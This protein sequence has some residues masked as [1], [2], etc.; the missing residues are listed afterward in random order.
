MNNNIHNKK[1]S[2]VTI[3]SRS[4]IQPYM[5]LQLPL[6]DL[7]QSCLILCFGLL[8]FTESIADPE[9]PLCLEEGGF[10]HC[11]DAK[12]HWVISATIHS[13]INNKDYDML[14][15]LVI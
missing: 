7:F 6:R 4:C 2:S 5:P 11:V 9:E 13:D 8:W 12:Q 3:A 15:L 10:H 14:Y 1:P